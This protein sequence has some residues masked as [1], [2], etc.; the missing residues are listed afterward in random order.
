MRWRKIPHIQ[1]WAG[2][3]NRKH[4]ATIMYDS[5]AQRLTIWVDGGNV[6]QKLTY[7]SIAEDAPL[8][9]YKALAEIAHTSLAIDVELEKQSKEPT[10]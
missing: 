9:T 7:P 8:H 1:K 5:E 10:Q 2:Y 3:R 4:A 6:F